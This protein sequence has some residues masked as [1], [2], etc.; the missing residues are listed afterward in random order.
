MTRRS[1]FG[2]VEL[3]I[4]VAIV[5]V[6][7]AL[8]A[9]GTR[10]LL[11]RGRLSEALNS[12]EAQIGQARRLA[13]RLDRAVT[14]QITADGATWRTVVDGVAADI[15]GGAVVTSGVATISFDAPF[16]TYAGNDV[17]IDLAINGVAGTVVVTGVLAR[18]VVLR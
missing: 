14:F 17:E 9:I 10:G 12:V 8:G 13:K 7:A 5:G 11:E 6:L 3:L 18:T 16:G 15:P 2:L 4:V 1:G